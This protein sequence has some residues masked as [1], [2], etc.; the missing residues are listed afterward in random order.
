MHTRTVFYIS[1]GTTLWT[2][3]PEDALVTKLDVKSSELY[4]QSR[5]LFGQGNL[6]EDFD[7]AAHA[8]TPEKDGFGLLLK[9]KKSAR[10]FK[11]LVLV[12]DPSTGEI[13]RTELTDP[14]DNVSIVT[15]QKL[16]YRTLDEKPFRFTPPANATIRD[17]SKQA[18]ASK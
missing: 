1:D 9:P 3:Q 8:A 16:E 6:T 10:D 2:Y 12:V 4:H 17:L 18:P 15:F 7:V 14:Y 5:Y 11:Q 13:R